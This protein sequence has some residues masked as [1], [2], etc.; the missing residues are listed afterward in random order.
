MGNV[1]AKETRSRSSSSVSDY[2]NSTSPPPMVLH[3]Q[4]LLNEETLHRHYME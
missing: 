4:R 1:P 2:R 3:R